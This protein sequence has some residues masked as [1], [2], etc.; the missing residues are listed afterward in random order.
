MAD[1][2]PNLRKRLAAGGVFAV[3]ATTTIGGFE[4]IRQT[5]YPDPATR[6]PPWTVCYGHTG[7]G[8]A[9][10]VRKSVAQ[11]RELLRQDLGKEAAVLDRCLHGPISDG[12]GV[13]FLSLATNIGP[14][15]FCRSSVARAF[16][17]GDY[18]QACNNL[19]HFDRAAGII[20]P[21]LERRRKA[22][23]EICLYE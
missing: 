8:V 15:G 6:G 16:N 4:G 19:L 18:E 1:Q 3:M 11:C 13:A 12:Q 2:S 10:G 7:R 22:E 5:A 23:R 21:G 20:F 17:R 14:S 9:P